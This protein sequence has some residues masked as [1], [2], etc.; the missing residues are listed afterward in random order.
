MRLTLC[1]SHKEIVNK[2]MAST[3]EFDNSNGSNNS[4]YYI[5]TGM[6]LPPPLP[7]PSA[8]HSGQVPDRD[9]ARFAADNQRTSVLQQL[10]R[11][12][13]VV[14]L[15]KTAHRKRTAL[16][17]TRNLRQPGPTYKGSSPPRPPPACCPR[18]LA[19]PSVC[20]CRAAG[21]VNTARDV[22]RAVERV[23]GAGIVRAWQGRRWKCQGN[24]G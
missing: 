6:P 19:S 8:T 4:Y 15:L 18:S 22:G 2:N 12:D 20:S 16:Q 3:T 24:G 10:D 11:A 1:V 23:G 17:K 14:A 21:G 5:T 7:P 9:R 13:I